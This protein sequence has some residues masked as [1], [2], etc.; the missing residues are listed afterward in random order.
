MMRLIAD[1][2]DLIGVYNVGAGIPGVAKAITDA[3]RESTITFIG[4]DLSDR[5]PQVPACAA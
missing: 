5:H 1:H 3:G 4:H 2:P